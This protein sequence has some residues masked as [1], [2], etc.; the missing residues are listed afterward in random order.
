MCY[1]CIQ[2][3]KYKLKMKKVIALIRTSTD[4]QQVESQKKEI[5]SM[6][7]KDGYSE[8]EIIVV[9]GSGASAIKVDEAY[10]ANMNK[11]YELI[12][13]GE[14]K[15]VYAW[16]V[17]RIGR[18]RRQLNNFRDT[19]L[20]KKV[21][22]IIKNPSA[23]LL[24]DDG[25]EDFSVSIVFSLHIEQAIF[26]MQQKQARFK[27]AKVGNAQKGK[28]NGGSC[29]LFGYDLDKNGYYIP[30]KENAEI[31][32]LAFELMASGNFST[33]KL[34]QEFRNRG[35]LIYGNK[36]TDR[37]IQLLLKKTAYIGYMNNGSYRRVYPR[38][39]SDELFNKVQEVIANNNTQQ[40][41]ATKHYNFASLLITCSEC[42]RHFVK[43][44]EKYFCSKH[45]ESEG[46]RKDDDKCGNSLAI[47]ISHLDGLLWSI[48]CDMHYKTIR[49]MDERKKQELKD[50]IKVLKEKLTESNRSL[51][52]DINT[53]LEDL[54][55]LYFSGRT[56]KDR[57]ERLRS[58]I[59]KDEERIKN[60]IIRYQEEI[61]G[62]E[63]LLNLEK[64]DKW[65][66]DNSTLEDL[67]QNE[68]EKEMSDLVHQYISSIS[69]ERCKIPS[70]VDGIGGKMAVE[71]V[72][73][74][75]NDEE[76]TYYYL[77]KIRDTKFRMFQVFGTKSERVIYEQIIR[78]EGSATTLST[79]LRKAFDQE[80]KNYLNGFKEED[81]KNALR[82]LFNN[83][84]P[85]YIE[86]Y[87][88]GV[89]NA[90][91]DTLKGLK[92]AYQDIQ[93]NREYLMTVNKGSEIVDLN[94]IL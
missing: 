58:T 80:L 61:R 89:Y 11:V 16:S 33:I 76:Q 83:I 79:Q 78:E 41:K 37:F 9:G 55:D 75:V 92:Q 52:E 8:E 27:T 82:N 57:Y 42:G 74:F 19:L 70:D 66:K 6:I 45:K 10:L 65:L 54:E 36:A 40:P 1:L 29:P 39:I 85:Q 87:N 49:D 2:K 21:Q 59:S 5:I 60:D 22:L 56:S 25:T 91:N 35:I 68:N 30:H 17:D 26:E 88:Y 81:R 71:I 69:L 15:C 23:K 67:K 53:R 90:E 84:L 38:L 3:P 93:D 24:N 46:K 44:H 31:V 43:S 34:T 50:K 72:I 63:G 86:E 18:N 64:S 73:R 62:V 47:S 4:R 20:E 51:K 12:E 14:I 28:F 7:L 48:V 13:S 77:P 94:T 32:K